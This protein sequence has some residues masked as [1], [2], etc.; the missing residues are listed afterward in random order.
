[1]K[2]N[3]RKVL[4]IVLIVLFLTVWVA[5]ESIRHSPKYRFVRLVLYAVE[6][7]LGLLFLLAQRAK[8]CP[9]CK[10]IYFGK[11]KYCPGCGQKLE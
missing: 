9:Q 5:V 10:K 1:M 8:V 4:R 3:L 11:E 7:I 2:K 6:L